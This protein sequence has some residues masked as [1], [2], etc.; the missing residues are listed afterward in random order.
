MIFY[1][2]TEFQIFQSLIYNLLT[3]L[4]I[5]IDGTFTDTPQMGQIGPRSNS[6]R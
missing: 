4:F 6:Y 5:L 1:R 3:D 2:I